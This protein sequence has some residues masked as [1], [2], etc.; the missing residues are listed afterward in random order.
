MKPHQYVS[1]L[2]MGN[3]MQW[4]QLQYREIVSCKYIQKSAE[5][6]FLVLWN[7]MDYRAHI[8]ILIAFDII[9]CTACE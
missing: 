6:T 4:K 7:S 8:I 3:G 2:S 9:Y 5:G 1:L